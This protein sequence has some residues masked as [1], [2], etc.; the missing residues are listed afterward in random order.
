[1]LILYFSGTGNSQYIARQFA[2]RMQADCRSIEEEADFSALLA[3]TDTVAVCYP[4]YG[5]SVPR[6]MREFASRHAAQFEGKRLIIFCTQMMFSG[7]GA[8]AFTRLLPG[9]E[10]RVI[11][12]EHFNMPNNISN[13][14][15][16]PVREGERIRK[17]RAADKRLER[18]CRDLENGVVRRRGWGVRSM[19]L[20]KLQS[21]NWLAIEEKQRGSF[22]ADE[23]C[24]RCGLCVRRCPVQN[25]ELTERGVVQ[26]NRCILC[27]R[28]VNLCPQ[29]A[30]TVMLHVKPKRQYKGIILSEN[31]TGG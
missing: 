12:A 15:L 17:Q 29:K 10:S 18:V 24:S 14:W 6:I 26:K 8:K 27:Y 7:D 16:F 22:V 21:R 19:L 9:C 5:S 31:R 23:D 3:G 1:M 20:G 4:I 2:A 30:A 11:Y 25:L 13:F 28:C